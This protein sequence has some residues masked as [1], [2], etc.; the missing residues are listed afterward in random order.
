MK[1]RL[2]ASSS[3]ASFALDRA[4]QHHGADALGD[5][6]PGGVGVADARSLQFFCVRLTRLFDLGAHSGPARAISGPSAVKRATLAAG[7][8]TWKLLR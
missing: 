4:G 7:F 1:R 5:Q 8:I 3:F 6:G 2:A